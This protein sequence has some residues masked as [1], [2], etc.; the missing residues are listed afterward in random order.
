[1]MINFHYLA[2]TQRNMLL[3]V[4]VPSGGMEK[5]GL[6]QKEIPPSSHIILV[7]HPRNWWET[8]FFSSPMGRMFGC[9]SENIFFALGQTLTDSGQNPSHEVIQNSTTKS[10]LISQKMLSCNKEDAFLHVICQ[11]KRT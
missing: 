3:H 7:I 4:S 10:A 5:V 1:M 9:D 2:A 11:N 6:I 8:P